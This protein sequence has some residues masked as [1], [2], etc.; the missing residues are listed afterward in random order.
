MNPRRISKS[1][2]IGDVTVGGGAPIVVQSMTKTDTRDVK[3]TVAQIRELEE[4]G[5]EL[6]S[7]TDGADIY[8]LNTCTVTH[9]ADRKCR[10]RLRAAHVRNPGGLV[11]AIGCYAERAAKDL[12]RI[13]GVGMVLGSSE[14]WQ[15]INRLKENGYSFKSASAQDAVLETLSDFRTR[16]FIR[17]QDGCNSFCAYCIVPLVRGSEQSLSPGKVI[18]DI[19]E[20]V[21]KGYK[22][23]VLTGTKVGSYSYNGKGLKGLIERILAE[24]DIER[25]RLS[26]LQPQELSPE[27][28]G[29]WQNNRLCRHFHLSLQSGSNGVLKR[30]N[31]RYTVSDY[32]KAV[33]L[34]RGMV[35]DVAITTDVIVG[36]PGETE[37]DFKESYELCRKMGFARMHIF[38]YSPRRGTK[39][40]TMPEREGDKA[41][42]ERAQKMLRLAEE[43]AKEFRKRFLGKAMP[44]LWEKKTGE[45]VWSGLTDNYVRVYTRSSRDLTGRILPV[46]L[47][48]IYK[49]GVWG[50]AWLAKG[51]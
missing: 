14:K 46:K 12:S 43:S 13:K 19:T 50:E 45:G 16:A 33:D 1:V 30:M 9:I 17:V 41:K 25:L 4:A 27:L 29:L 40:S 36:F 39:A 26:S 24:T 6:V 5:C 32:K 34:I 35:P 47:K 11:V 23:V 22:E 10:R 37:A 18:A 31:R 44:V 3:A 49:D 15:L 8:V 38:P 51:G 2:R 42:R 28:I 7:A 21:R 48:E 20:S